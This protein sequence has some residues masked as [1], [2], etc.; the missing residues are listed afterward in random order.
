MPESEQSRSGCPTRSYELQLREKLTRGG[1]GKR[2]E[3][4]MKGD[5]AGTAR[6]ELKTPK[7]EGDSRLSSW[8]TSSIDDDHPAD[9]VHLAAH[10]PYPR[11]PTRPHAGHRCRHAARPYRRHRTENQYP[12]SH[13]AHRIHH[14]PAQQPALPAHSQ[15]AALIVSASPHGSPIP[16]PRDRR[17]AERAWGDIAFVPSASPHPLYRRQ[18]KAPEGR[19]RR[20]GHV[21]A[22]PVPAH[23]RPQGRATLH[24]HRAHPSARTHGTGGQQNKEGSEQ[25]PALVDE[26][27]REIDAIH[28][29]GRRE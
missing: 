23:T 9:P 10:A 26:Q 25:G 14:P 27:R 24:A 19:E 13:I 11:T 2:R 4:K 7:K 1:V 18:A 28:R 12:S 20:A 3:E 21:Q 22:P 29:R 16:R 15:D 8:N 5:E 6:A 17:A